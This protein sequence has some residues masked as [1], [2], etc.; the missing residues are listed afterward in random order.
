MRKRKVR[1]AV[2]VGGLVAMLLALLVLAVGCG[3][4]PERDRH[5][6]HQPKEL[7]KIALDR[8]E[9]TPAFYVKLASDKSGGRVLLAVGLYRGTVHSWVRVGDTYLVD[10]AHGDGPV[11]LEG[12]HHYTEWA[13]YEMRIRDTPGEE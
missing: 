11:R 10:P 7:R 9:D 13:A 6:P 8:I 3:S 4:A 5:R 12:A 1:T 2:I